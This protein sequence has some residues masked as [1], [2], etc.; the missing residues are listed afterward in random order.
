[1]PP[2][3][4]KTACNPCREKKRKCNGHQPCSNCGKSGRDCI[5]VL[6]PR[7][8]RYPNGVSSNPADLRE[9]SSAAPERPAAINSGVVLARKLAG[10]AIVPFPVRLCSWNLGQMPTLSSMISGK[11][12][13]SSKLVSEPSSITDSVTGEYLRAMVDSYF[14]EIHPVYNFLDPEMVNRAV[15][16][17]TSE[18]PSL[19]HPKHCLLLNICALGAHFLSEDEDRDSLDSSSRIALEYSTTLET[20]TLDHVVAWLLRVFYLRLTGSP[21]ATWLASC[22]LMHFIETTELHIDPSCQAQSSTCCNEYDPELRRRIYGVARLFHMW[23]S[24]DYGHTPMELRGATCSLPKESWTSDEIAVWQISDSLNPDRQLDPAT[25]EQLLHQTVELKLPHTV[26]QLKRCNIGLCIYRRLRVAGCS[27]SNATVN[28]VLGLVDE[29]HDLVD[30]L[31]AESLPWWHILNVPFQALCVL[32]ALDTRESLERVS[33]TLSTLRMIA[34]N[35]YTDAVKETLASACSL[36]CIH[37]QRKKDD[38]HLLRKAE[39]YMLQWGDL[40][41]P[42]LNDYPIPS[43][44]PASPTAKPVPTATDFPWDFDQLVSMNMFEHW[45]VDA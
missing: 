25:L 28:K 44:E 2:D 23:I 11:V 9:S 30:E 8:R 6:N 24:Y 38:I 26:Q 15:D 42:F 4:A 18:R 12:S 1:M 5:Y 43:A 3:R 22:T 45:N 27:V 19:C 36:L 10:A 14:N 37:S 40:D 7:K 39:E 41:A 13:V 33:Q 35:Y 31:A 34:Q 32:L 16:Y 17:V 29:I 20:P 21:H